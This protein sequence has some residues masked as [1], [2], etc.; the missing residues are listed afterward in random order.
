MSQPVTFINVI[1]VDPARQQEL[2]DLLREGT[3]RVMTQRPGFVSVTLLASA[4]GRRV[5]NLA[6]W[7][8][9]EDVR[10]TQSDPAAAEYA[11]RTAAIASA[12][13]PGLYAVVAE[14]P[15]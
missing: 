13:A 15:G 12:A 2:I 14:Y 6:R 9:A 7:E 10:A 4:D 5:V 3:E 1:D 8:R 11:R